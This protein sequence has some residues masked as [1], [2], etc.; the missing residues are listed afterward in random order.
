MKLYIIKNVNCFAFSMENVFSRL[1]Q[2][3]QKVSTKYFSKL[4][5]FSFITDFL[6]LTDFL[7]GFN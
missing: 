1:Q 2:N 6:T 3:L 4:S 5:D 7:T